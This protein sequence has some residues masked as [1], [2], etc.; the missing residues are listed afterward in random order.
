M[1]K[2]NII[3]AGLAF[4]VSTGASAAIITLDDFSNTSSASTTVTSTT[5]GSS[6]TATRTVT[7]TGTPD[8]AGIRSN[9]LEL[10]NGS[11][12]AGTG[13]VKVNYAGIT[14]LEA[15]PAYQVVFTVLRAQGS[16]DSPMIAQALIGPDAALGRYEV[17]S[18][19]RNETVYSGVVST[20]SNFSITLTGVPATEVD[21]RIQNVGI[22]SCANVRNPGVTGTGTV[23]GSV[24]GGTSVTG[25]T[26]TCGTAVPA[27][28][29]L[30]LLGLGFAGLAAFRRKAK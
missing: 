21:F 6:A 24:I 17:V 25:G 27:P 29:S 1:N 14:G 28:A 8:Y 23:A 18:S 3:A 20:L 26:V 11:I 9:A 2:L 22:A 19:S 16:A 15:S 7:T 5:P 12:S 4:M 13:T 30:A 10:S